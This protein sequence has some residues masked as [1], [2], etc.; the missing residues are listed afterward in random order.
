MIKQVVTGLALLTTL[1]TATHAGVDFD[2]VIRARGINVEFSSGSSCKQKLRTL[3]R[4]IVNLNNDLMTCEA[5]N[6]DNDLRPRLRELRRENKNLKIEVE[7]LRRLLDATQGDSQDDELSPELIGDIL[8]SCHGSYSSARSCLKNSI[9]KI[10]QRGLD[11]RRIRAISAGCAVI[12]SSTS[13]YNCY[14]N[15]LKNI[16]QNLSAP[17]GHLMTEMCHGSYDDA[18]ACLYS[19]SAE[20][21]SA[22]FSVDILRDSCQEISSTTSRYNCLYKGLRNK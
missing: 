5:Q 19:A 7:E 17:L 20:Y 12:K 16:K 10:I 8:D 1:S 6:R 3:K 22:N 9:D 2:G 11:G 13:G 18:S 21:A 15:G 14:Y 4:E